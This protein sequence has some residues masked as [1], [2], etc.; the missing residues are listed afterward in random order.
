V[1][2]SGIEI[3]Q[4]IETFDYEGASQHRE[5]ITACSNC[6]E[7]MIVTHKRPSFCLDCQGRTCALSMKTFRRFY[8]C[9]QWRRMRKIVFEQK[10]RVCVYCQKPATHIDHSTPI[11]RG[12]TNDL[13]N[14]EPV[15]GPCNTKK[16]KKT[17]EEYL[18]FLKNRLA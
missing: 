6:G 8:R 17:L 15:C 4:P 16:M 5:S 3:F 12:G 14:L 18:L 9:S 7:W 1:D 13:F 2:K 10:G 11:C